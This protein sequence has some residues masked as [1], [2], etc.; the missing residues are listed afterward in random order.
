M[1]HMYGALDGADNLAAACSETARGPTAAASIT[2]DTRYLEAEQ[3]L[4]VVYVLTNVAMPGLIKIGRTAAD[5]VATRL[6]QLYST[7]VPFPF[8]LQFA[9][10]VPNS[11]EVEKA[12][13]IAFSPYRINARRE[14]FKIEAEQAIAILKLLHVVDE[15]PRIEAQATMVPKEDVEAAQAFTSKRPKMNFVEMGIPIGS[16]LQLIGHSATAIVTSDRKVR[17]GDEEMSLTAATRML[18]GLNHNIQPS[19]LWSF[20][21]RSLKDIYEET[22]GAP[23]T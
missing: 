15:T 16:T 5:D 20:E 3:M 4:E 10:S 17:V 14:F 1:Q 22:Y 2:D 13:H 18:M 11:S 8:D 19:P 21:G 12:L 7:G 9:C 6:G 23:E